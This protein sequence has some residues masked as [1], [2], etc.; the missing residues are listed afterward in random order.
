MRVCDH[1]G[2]ICETELHRVWQ[3]TTITQVNLCQL[4]PL[5][6]NWRITSQQSFTA[7]MPLLV[8]T[9]AFIE[10]HINTDCSY[11]SK[12]SS[13]STP[14]YNARYPGNESRHGAVVFITRATVI[15]LQTLTAVQRSTQPSTVH[16]TIK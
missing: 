5:V 11:T 12:W 15:W 2:K 1:A 14:D 4:A 3:T 8:A 6:N 13:S 16:G 9:S 7:C 10:Q